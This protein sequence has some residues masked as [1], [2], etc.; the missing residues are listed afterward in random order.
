MK[1]FAPSVLAFLLLAAAA[2]AFADA[3]D[4]TGEAPAARC[5]RLSTDDTLLPVPESLA[6]EVNAAFG[7]ALPP[8]SIPATT[9]YRC[10]AGQ[11]MVCTAGANLPCGKADTSRTPG[12]GAVSWCK[13]NPQAD[14][15]PAYAT[16]HDTIFAWRC[17]DGAALVEKQLLD[18]DAQGFI[19][20]FWKPLY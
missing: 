3:S 10:V 14:F 16:G 17:K 7:T 18:V 1:L 6:I 2:P 12:E 8:A 19:K 5:A 15:I 4:Q 13:Q 9:V 11:V 20:Q